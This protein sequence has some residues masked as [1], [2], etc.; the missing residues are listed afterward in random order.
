MRWMPT[1]TFNQEHIT[2]LI[3]GKLNKRNTMQK[4]SRLEIRINKETKDN[5]QIIASHLT[6]TGT[7]T[8]LLLD[9]IENIIANNR[10]LLT[11]SAV[12]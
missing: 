3:T 9:L 7:V 2:I 10:K 5:L 1:L 11:E 8:E 6:T 12:K 4:D